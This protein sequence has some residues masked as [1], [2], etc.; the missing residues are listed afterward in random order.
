MRPSG[1]L[2]NPR[3]PLLCPASI[4]R[5]DVTV[6]PA[7]SNQEYAKKLANQLFY[8]RAAQTGQ[9]YGYSG[10]GYAGNSEASNT[11]INWNSYTKPI[12]I[13]PAN[14][15]RV[16]IWLVEEEAAKNGILSRE[17]S[18]RPV[19]SE[20]PVNKVISEGVSAVPLPS[21]RYLHHGSIQ[22]EG[23]IE[24][25]GQTQSEGT[26]SSCVIVCGE[27]AWEIH[28]LSRF[29]EGPLRGQ[30]KCG[31][32]HYQPAVSQWS[33][34]CAPETGTLSASGL[35]AIL[36]TISLYDL[37]KVLEGGTIDHA[38]SM[39]AIVTA[40]AHLEPA[41]A[42][43]HFP[44]KFPKLKNGEPNPA[45]TTEGPEG[46]GTFDAVPEGLRLRFPTASRAAEYS[47]IASNFLSSAIYEAGRKYGFYIRD[48]SGAVTINI[49][50]PRTLFTRYCDTDVDP[51]SGAA[52]Y[53]SYVNFG[54]TA[55]EREAWINNSHQASLKTLPTPLN[56]VGGVLWPMPWRTLEAVEQSAS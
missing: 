39:S 47:E 40:N 37:A 43:D 4:F 12:Y 35:S 53:E 25:E 27:E 21:P 7:M 41:N 49:A 46:P 55:K 48:S 20:H 17:E 36:G 2:L 22:G 9:F 6:H 8:N 42:N 29:A 26:D 14:Q 45:Y 34:V 1:A 19:G 50:D 10:I 54:T 33:G 11:K 23:P 13:V 3:G 56:G 51:F 24:E 32:A 52:E 44:N 18:L 38:I 5:D 16:K 15:R 28:R 30:Y 31:Y